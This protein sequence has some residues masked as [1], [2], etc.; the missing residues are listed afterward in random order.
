MTHACFDEHEQLK[1]VEEAAEYLRLSKNTLN[2]N[3][4]HGGGPAFVRVGGRIRYRL[5]DLRAYVKIGRD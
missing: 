3:R 2:W 4:S 1:T 5:S